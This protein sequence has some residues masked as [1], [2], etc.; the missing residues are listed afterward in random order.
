MVILSAVTAW[1]MASNMN[2]DESKVRFKL[3]QD[4]KRVK[5]EQYNYNPEKGKQLYMALCAKCHMER[6][7]G[8]YQYPPLSGS[9]L[10]VS[11]VENTAKIVVKGLRGPIKRTGKEYNGAMPA[12]KAIG[13]YDLAHVINYIRKDFNK[14]QDDV[15]PVEIVKAKID[16]LTIKGALQEKDLKPNV[17][18][19]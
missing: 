18:R 2:K 13:H 14:I 15:H 1:I 3:T 6:G 8:N 11:D 4:Y 16:T 7:A 12:F 5:K 17:L 19:K 9:T 10:V